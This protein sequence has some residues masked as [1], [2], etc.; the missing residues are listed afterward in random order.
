MF[1]KLIYFFMPPFS[2]FHT[3]LISKSVRPLAPSTR[4]LAKNMSSKRGQP[5]NRAPAPIQ[6]TAE[7]MVLEA[8]DLKLDYVPPKPKTRS[9]DY[10]STYQVGYADYMQPEFK[11]T[12]SH[13]QF[14]VDPE[15][16]KKP[17]GMKTPRERTLE[18]MSMDPQQIAADL[19]KLTQHSD[20]F[21]KHAPMEG[22]YETVLAA[23]G[24]REG[25][26]RLPGDNRPQWRSA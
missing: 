25:S 4:V 13:P 5:K 1:S 20:I 6:I 8:T 22:H 14:K 21:H 23:A 15:N 24:Q 10:R 7:Q 18:Q 19:K 3:A 2:Q 12:L 16:L 26:K 11:L 9:R 17:G